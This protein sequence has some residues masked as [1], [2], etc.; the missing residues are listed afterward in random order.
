MHMRRLFL[1]LFVFSLFS[2][3]SYAGTSL[4]NPQ[5]EF[6]TNRGSFVVELYP[7]KAPQTVANFMQYVSNGFYQ[8]TTFHRT[9]ERFMIQGGGLDEHLS[10][11]RTLAP[12]PNESNNGLKNEPG[13]LAMARAYDPNSA[14]SQF[15][16]NLTDNKFLNYYKP[17]PA[18]IGYAVFGK[19]IRG[20]DIVERIS[21]TSTRKIGLHQNVPVEPIVIEKVAILDRPVLAEAAPPLPSGPIGSSHVK[22]QKS[23]VKGKK[24]D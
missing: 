19:V 20:M 9:I 15:F 6:L 11:K 23:S 17:E 22:T 24:R 1:A 7:D 10:E 3:I 8:G 12:I 5:V 18:Y 4:S 14:T 16:I 2:T 21:K 13:T